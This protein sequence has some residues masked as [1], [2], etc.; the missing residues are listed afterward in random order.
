LIRSARVSHY[1]HGQISVSGRSISVLCPADQIAAPG[2]VHR[3]FLV[4]Q[5]IID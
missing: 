3:G 1:V 2:I 4:Q 5:S